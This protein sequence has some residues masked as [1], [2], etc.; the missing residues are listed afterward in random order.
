MRYPVT[1][2]YLGTAETPSYAA[3]MEFHRRSGARATIRVPGTALARPAMSPGSELIT[4]ATSKST[5]TAT[6]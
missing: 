2:S 3:E 5:H 4:I 6:T 1:T